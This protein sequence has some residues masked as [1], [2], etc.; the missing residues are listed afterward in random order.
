MGL[1]KASLIAAILKG[2]VSSPVPNGQELSVLNTHK[3]L[4][5]M[6][7]LKFFIDIFCHVQVQD[8]LLEEKNRK[9]SGGNP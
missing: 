4:N 3:E 2:P 1:E 9:D 8:I 7:F 6:L 5:K